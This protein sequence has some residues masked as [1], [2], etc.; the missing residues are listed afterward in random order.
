MLPSPTHEGPPAKSLGGQRQIVQAEPLAETAARRNE[1]PARPNTSRK[2]AGTRANVSDIVNLESPFAGK[3]MRISPVSLLLFF[4]LAFGLTLHPSPA[5]A[6]PTA[7][8]Q[9][10]LRSNCRSDFMSLCSGVP[11]GGAEALQCLQRNVAKLSP[12]CQSAVNAVMPRSAPPPA[13]AV[14]PPAPPPSVVAAPPAAPPPPPATAPATARQPPA[15]PPAAPTRTTTAP[16]PA[17]KPAAK[18]EMVPAAPSVAAPGPMP[19][20]TPRVQIAVARACDGDI[21]AVCKLVRPGSGRVI[22]CL[23]ENEPALSPVCKQALNNARSGR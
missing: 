14:P 5:A 21:Q 23:V 15:H 1:I 4:G 10:A 9:D 22:E 3:N 6:Q 12:G 17:P 8:Q 11:R 16:A 13:A 7:Q 19:P 2:A 18:P 20:I